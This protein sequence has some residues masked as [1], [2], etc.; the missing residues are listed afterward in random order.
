[1]TRAHLD[2]RGSATVLGLVASFVVL[3][4]G[5]IGIVQVQATLA[6]H[7][8]Q[9]AADLSALAGAQALADSCGAAN[10]MAVAN[11]VDLIACEIAAGDVSVVVEARTPSLV[12][13]LLN[14]FGLPIGKVVA[15]AKAGPPGW[16]FSS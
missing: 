5:F 7:S 16:W 10:Q 14:R 8:V 12:A 2:D 15:T 3:S 9:S 6:S 13:E 1:V 11:N 4:V